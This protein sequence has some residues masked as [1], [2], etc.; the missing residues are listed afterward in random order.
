MNIFDQTHN[1]M[2]VALHVG[3]AADLNIYVVQLN[4]GGIIGCARNSWALFLL[5]R[6]SAALS[7]GSA[8]PLPQQLTRRSGDAQQAALGRSVRSVSVDAEQC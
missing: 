1:D 3:G 2:K 7:L 4:N 8:V 5:P 6:P